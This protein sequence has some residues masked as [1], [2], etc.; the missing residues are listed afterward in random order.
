MR[1]PN[2]TNDVLSFHNYGF[3]TRSYGCARVSFHRMRNENMNLSENVPPVNSIS[4]IGT[5][6]AVQENLN[7]FEAKNF[8]YSISTE[9]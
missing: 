9:I 1:V 3:S 6:T 4:L 2:C 5:A 8:H 7:I